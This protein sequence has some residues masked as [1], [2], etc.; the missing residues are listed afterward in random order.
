MDNNTEAEISLLDRAKIFQRV[1][2]EWRPH[3]S[4]VER[5]F[6]FYLLDNTIAWGRYS[7]R[8]TID[9][10]VKGAAWGLPPAGLSRSTVCRLLRVF[11]ERG[12][13]DSETDGRKTTLLINAGWSPFCATR[14]KN[15]IEDMDDN[16]RTKPKS[17]NFSPEFSGDIDISGE[18]SERDFRSVRLRLQ[19]S[20]CDTPKKN[21]KKERKAEKSNDAARRLVLSEII[22]K[23][24]GKILP[25]PGSEAK[26]ELVESNWAVWR[27]A[28]IATYP[29]TPC[30][31]WKKYE[32]K[33]MDRLRGQSARTG[34]NWADFLNWVVCHW[35]SLRVSHFAWMKQTPA[36]AF[37]TVAFFIRFSDRFLD[38]YA[39]REMVDKHSSDFSN[40]AAIRKMM[41]SGMSYEAALIEHGKQLA[42]AEQREQL[43]TKRKEL[44]LLERTAER[45][46]QQSAAPAK[47]H[48]VVPAVRVQHGDNP[49]DKPDPV[50]LD[51]GSDLNWEDSVPNR[52]G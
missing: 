51:D 17:R 7:L 16:R 12:L 19:K 50:D 9:Q 25:R 18:V 23:E 31:G 2:R 8:T 37:P 15:E 47:A 11:K 49:F 32:A 52:E 21:K 27:D 48:P 30:S 35:S 34:V 24:T 40:D 44:A 36:P 26:T 46:R 5:D 41:Q 4:P 38:A 45:M 10:I 22:D 6:L 39:N 29:D 20:L 13:I 28:W 42:M 33:H 14:C 3:L 43:E 1:N